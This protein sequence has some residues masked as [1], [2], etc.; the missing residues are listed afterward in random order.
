MGN[1]IKFSEEELKDIAN[2]Y[3]NEYNPI[4]LI[5]KK[6]NVDASVITNRLK[7]QDIKIAKGSA[8]SKK[9]WIERGLSEEEAEYKIKLIKPTFMEYWLD[10]G[11]SEEESQL[12]IDGQRLATLRGYIFKY[13]KEEGTKLWFTRQLENKNGLHSK[14]CVPY[15]LNKGYTE[16]MAKIEISKVQSTFSL[17]KCLE[18]YGEEEGLK[19]F[20]DRQIKWSDS[21][22]KNGNIKMGYSKISQ[23]LFYEILNHIDINNREFIYFATHNKEIKFEK[24][25]GGI[26]L[27]DFTDLENKK[28]I[29]FNGDMYHGNPNKYKANDYPHPFRKTTTAKEIWDKDK[30]KLDVAIKKGFEVLV[31]WD[32]EY[33]L[34]NKQ[35]IV[36]KCVEFLNKK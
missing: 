23:E 3:L 16:E 7:K 18:K 1:F 22:N 25:N 9:Y 13:G 26:W 10:K 29:E 34:G 17:K 19:R 31:I 4:Y 11:F 35:E 2:M 15:W 33:R 20:T 8:Y 6:Y 24:E 5:A 21:L 28:I 36:R 14:R 32:S 30:Q 12:R 27:Y